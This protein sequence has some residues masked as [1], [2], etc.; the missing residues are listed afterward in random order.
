VLFGGGFASDSIID[1]IT[2]TT[3]VKIG[4]I[5]TEFSRYANGVIYGI[6]VH[7]NGSEFETRRGM[8]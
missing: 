2:K 8:N 1:T 7:R 3:T 5:P 4:T 6:R